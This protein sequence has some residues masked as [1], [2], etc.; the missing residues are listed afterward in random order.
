[1]TD[2]TRSQKRRLELMS[3]ACYDATL[4]Y[5]LRT[6]LPLTRETYLAM[7]YPDRVPNPVPPE[8]EAQIPEPLR[9]A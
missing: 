4:A 2:I 6:N 8:L 3:V 1:M 9:L 5:M 7:E